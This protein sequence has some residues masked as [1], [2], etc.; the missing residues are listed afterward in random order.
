M[1]RFYLYIRQMLLMAIR[2]RGQWWQ[3]K[4][5]K[6]LELWDR[7]IPQP[8]VKKNVGDWD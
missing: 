6:F 2:R 4:I 3:M 1:R 5:A 8:A 7:Y